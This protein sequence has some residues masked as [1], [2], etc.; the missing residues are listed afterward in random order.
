MFSPALFTHIW[1]RQLTVNLFRPLL[2][3]MQ[4]AKDE[5]QVVCDSVGGYVRRVLNDQFSGSFYAPRSPHPRH[6]H[7]ALHRGLNAIVNQACGLP[8][9]CLDVIENLSPV[10]ESKD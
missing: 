5:N 7:Q 6:C 9:F 10:G 2:R 1:K 8:A 4:Y 3:A